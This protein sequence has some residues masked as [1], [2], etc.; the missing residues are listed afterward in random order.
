MPAPDFVLR[1]LGVVSVGVLLKLIEMVLGW[2][3]RRTGAPVMNTRINDGSDTFF[4]QDEK[5]W[6]DSELNIFGLIKIDPSAIMRRL[7]K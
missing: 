4:V 1:L 6:G 2:V 5:L 7:R 3:D